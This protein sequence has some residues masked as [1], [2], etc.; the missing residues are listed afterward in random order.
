MAEE[1][2]CG[3]GLV[4]TAFKVIIGLVLIGIGAWCV[5]TFWP[6]LIN[7]IKG[8]IGLFLIL[9]GAITVAIAKD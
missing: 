5:I 4:K 9:V 1:A 7:V 3:C 8:C 6:Q 2:K